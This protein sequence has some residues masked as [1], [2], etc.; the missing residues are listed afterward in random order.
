MSA[1]GMSKSDAGVGFA[2]FA[3]TAASEVVSRH[4]PVTWKLHLRWALGGGFGS[5]HFRQ[6][7]AY[8]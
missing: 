4:P 8:V 7:P 1:V 6:V 3:A 5:R 2:L